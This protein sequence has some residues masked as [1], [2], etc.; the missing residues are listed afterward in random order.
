VNNNTPHLKSA[1][2]TLLLIIIIIDEDYYYY[3]YYYYYYSL[4]EDTWSDSVS[5]RATSF[6]IISASMAKLDGSSDTWN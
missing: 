3:Y 1:T 2:I 4:N 6:T 5:S